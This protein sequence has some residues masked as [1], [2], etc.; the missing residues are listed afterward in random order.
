[1][2]AEGNSKALVKTKATNFAEGDWIT[3]PG[4]VYLKVLAVIDSGVGP[5]YCI[6]SPKTPNGVGWQS[7]YQLD[8]DGMALA[9]PDF[10]RFAKLKAGDILRVGTDDEDP[11][12]VVLARA[13]QAVLLSHVPD[14]KLASKLMELD[15]HLKQLA[16][17]S[18]GESIFEGDDLARIK[19]MGSQL[20]S[21]KIAGDWM[22]IR[23][24]ALMH[25]E[26]IEE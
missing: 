14:K 8:E 1:M 2:A 16:D 13:G 22:D 6:F 21:S 26:I 15:K 24:I 23:Q 25:W 17:L 10:S 11:Y 4:H 7:Q 3:A 5:M 19:K 12:V 18:D 9:E 20:H